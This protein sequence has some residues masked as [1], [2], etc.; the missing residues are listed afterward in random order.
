MLRSPHVTVD[1]FVLT[2]INTNAVMLGQFEPAICF[3]PAFHVCLIA[4]VLWVFSQMSTTKC[5]FKLNNF[6]N[7]ITEKCLNT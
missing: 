1:T 6:T 4:A 5:H 2:A 7:F 3:A